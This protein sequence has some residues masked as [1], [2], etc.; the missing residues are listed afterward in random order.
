LL[1]LDGGSPNTSELRDWILNGYDGFS[2]PKDPGYIWVTGSPGWRATLVHTMQEMANAGAR[3]T[4]L[5]FDEARGQGSNSEVR[6]IGVIE[7]TPIACDNHFV[8]ARL[9]SFTVMQALMV[10]AFDAVNFGVGARRGLTL[11]QWREVN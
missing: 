8:E 5:V 4:G 6:G 2:V 9:E 7:Y 11:E 1:N 3:M 10:S